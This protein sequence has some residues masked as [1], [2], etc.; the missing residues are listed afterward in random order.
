M[1]ILDW[2]TPGQA[3]NYTAKARRKKLAGGTMALL[4]DASDNGVEGED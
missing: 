3:R 1:A 2:K 4:V